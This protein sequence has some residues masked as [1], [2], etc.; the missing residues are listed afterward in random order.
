MLSTSLQQP[1]SHGKNKSKRNRTHRRSVSSEVQVRGHGE[2]NSLCPWIR[3][4]AAVT[5]PMRRS[6]LR[7]SRAY[8]WQHEDRSGCAMGMQHECNASGPHVV[9]C[10]TLAAR[11]LPGEPTQA[12]AKTLRTER[13][14]RQGARRRCLHFPA[15]SLSRVDESKC[16][17]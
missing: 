14:S 16:H 4:G 3:A 8:T 6:A 5:P 13:A 7:T 1:N 12:G 10:R 15:R 2:A 9:S 11:Q 17:E